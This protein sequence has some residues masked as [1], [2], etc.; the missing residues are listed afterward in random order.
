[1]SGNHA[2]I[3]KRFSF[4]SIVGMDRPILFMYTNG[5]KGTQA[6]FRRGFNEKQ[7]VLVWVRFYGEIKECVIAM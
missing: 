3:F 6:G 5:W 7:N 4:S 2:I 1:M